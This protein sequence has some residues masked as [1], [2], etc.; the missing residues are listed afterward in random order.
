MYT[1]AEMRRVVQIGDPAT[2]LEIHEWKRKF[3][4]RVREYQARKG[5]GA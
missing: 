5:E 3:D 2:V 4:G 1:A